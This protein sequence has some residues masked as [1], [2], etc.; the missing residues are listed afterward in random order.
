MGREK[1]EEEEEG[2]QKNLIFRPWPGLLD[3][4]RYLKGARDDRKC[5][6]NMELYIIVQ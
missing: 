1:L 4:L 3:R 2:V 5:Y 6:C